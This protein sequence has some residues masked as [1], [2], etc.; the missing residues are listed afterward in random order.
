MHFRFHLNEIVTIRKDQ[1][2]KKEEKGYA[3][4]V[5]NV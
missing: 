2:K 4:T 3:R 1:K 5:E